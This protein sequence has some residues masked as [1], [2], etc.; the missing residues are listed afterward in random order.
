[1][2]FFKELK[3]RNV[4]KVA[5][6]YAIAAWVILQVAELLFEA[7]EVP[8]WGLK[9]VLGL[10][11]IFFP[12]VLIFSWVYELTPEG[13]RR[14]RDIDRE[15]SITGQTGRK[16]NL[17]IVFLLV[18]AIAVQLF[19]R[20]SPVE[21]VG[22]HAVPVV[23]H[24]RGEGEVGRAASTQATRDATSVA[25]Q[26]FA[27]PPDR[28]IAVLPFASRSGDQNDIYFV[29]G[30][31]DEV[32]TRLSQ[33]GALKIIS[34]TSVMEYRDT[35]KN[36]RTIGEELQVAHLVE[37]SV[38]RAGDRIRVNVQLID[39]RTDE[40][41]WADIYDREM[42][43]ANLFE[44][45]S[46][47]A[48]AI[49]SALHASLTEGEQARLASIPTQDDV[50]YQEYLLGKQ[51][52]AR[53]SVPSLAKAKEHFASA[54]SRDP[55]FS[56]A[57]VGLADA[58]FLH[59]LY[60][61]AM[62][63]SR[64]DEV[65]GHI[66]R[67]LA[68]D[69]DIAEAYASL[70]NLGNT[71][72]WG[73][74]VAADAAFQRAIK[75][76]PNYA[77]AYQ[78]YSILLRNQGRIQQAYELLQRAVALDPLSAIINFNVG[79]TLEEMGRFDEAMAAY[80]RF[81]RLKPREPRIMG[82]I[83]TL[84]RFAFGR[85]AEGIRWYRRAEAIDP[86]TSN[87]VFAKAVAWSQLGEPERLDDLAERERVRNP[88][89]YRWRQARA[90]LLM[91]QGR[92]EE[93]DPLVREMLEL[94]PTSVFANQFMNLLDIGAGRNEELI[95]RIRALD[96]RLLRP[97]NPTVA[98]DNYFW[99][100]EVAVALLRS[101][102]EDQAN[103]LY[104][105]LLDLYETLPRRGFNGIWYYDVTLHALMG[106]REAALE[107][108]KSAID[109]GMFESWQYLY[110]TPEVAALVREPDFDAQM[111]RIRAHMAEQLALAREMEREDLAAR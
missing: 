60:N 87:V 38:Q 31:H 92:F 111:A 5:M 36:M 29:D 40:H 2:S 1:M 95:Q 10:L 105:A 75:L 30:M 11:V 62:T 88:D 81:H 99:A 24:D 57:H 14:E 21:T 54:V 98:R 13:I 65:R 44:V 70:G 9:L 51:E 107:S 43:A 100:N 108:L 46:E 27:P 91:R 76:N 35:V 32:L 17:L 45:Q 106:N 58:T 85:T 7:L 64:F 78:W 23:E 90:Y 83:G 89:G 109:D 102:E 16:I 94:S 41:L 104:R 3:R 97:G 18:A 74:P 86:D 71:P 93:A 28:S 22:D 12:L 34:R 53:R 52:M 6:L 20:L 80:L 4:A 73:D 79:S 33:I 110:F 49:A 25:G 37:G 103:A 68:L 56:L 72:P 63:E 66:D 84:N 8:E 47:I 61:N 39:A 77:P 59:A 15:A 96:P 55:E 101:G 26:R 42:T 50:A 48:R 69:P 67:A 19:D 82:Q